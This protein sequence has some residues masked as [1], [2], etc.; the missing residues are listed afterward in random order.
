MLEGRMSSGICIEYSVKW[1]T[2]FSN[3]FMVNQ[4]RITY[5]R[6]S[7]HQGYFFLPLLPFTS[8]W[9]RRDAPIERISLGVAL[10][11]FIAFE[12]IDET[13]SPVFLRAM[14]LPRV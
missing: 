8:S 3:P 7:H 1:A 13:L 12:A 4:I 11:V 5:Y 14:S 2:H 6:N 10:P 9:L